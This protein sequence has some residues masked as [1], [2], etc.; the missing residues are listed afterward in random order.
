MLDWIKKVKREWQERKLA[1]YHR[2]AGTA[3]IAF[4]RGEISLEAY[5]RFKK[6]SRP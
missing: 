6:D 5:E 3:W 4:E 1:E 2:I